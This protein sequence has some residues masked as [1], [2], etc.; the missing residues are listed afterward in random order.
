MARQPLIA[1]ANPTRP[2]QLN[3]GQ[4][5]AAQAGAFADL[6]QATA[7]VTNVFDQYAQVARDKALDETMR[8]AENEFATIARENPLAPDA[9]QKVADEKIGTLIAKSDG[10]IARD[11]ERGLINR[12]DAYLRSI[13]D[14]KFDFDVKTQRDNFLTGIDNNQN[15]LRSLVAEKGL[16]AA[17]LPEWQQSV[18]EALSRVDA[19]AA[20]PL[21]GVGGEEA[22]KLRDGIL[23]EA[24]TSLIVG[25]IGDEVDD[26][27][28]K[29]GASGA[30]KRLASL[31]DEHGSTLFA[32]E[33]LKFETHGER[34]IQSREAE[35]ERAIR[36]SEAARAKT[37]AE[38]YER[39][40]VDLSDGRLTRADADLLWQDGEIDTGHYASLV[41]HLNTRGKKSEAEA[42]SLLRIDA[43]VAEGSS[44]NPYSKTD[45]DDIDLYWSAIGGA[46]AMT[47]DPATARAML[48]A[49][50]T[51][52]GVIPPMAVDMLQGQM[53]HGDDAQRGEAI[54]TL[55]LLYER[56]PAAVEQ[57]LPSD[58]LGDVIAYSEMVNAGTPQAT[59]QARV[60]T[61]REARFSEPKKALLDAAK[62]SSKKIQSREVA[63]PVNGFF[64]APFA[65]GETATLKATSEYRR[66]YESAFVGSN[67]NEKAARK[68][69]I[70][71]LKRVYGV[72]NVTGSARTMPY[73]PERYYHVS[74]VDDK[75]MQAALK[76]EVEDWFG[77]RGSK[78]NLERVALIP[79]STTAAEAQQPGGRPGYR[80]VVEM[81]DGDQ[82][83]QFEEIPGRYYFPDEPIRANVEAKSAE[84]TA[85]KR[86]FAAGVREAL[87]ENKT[88]RRPRG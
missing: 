48:A 58:Q 81:K 65:G 85:K 1:P 7:Q 36:E 24:Q 4:G 14:K 15:T 60:D 37:Q 44:L 72:S 67:G 76:A 69:A 54:D 84:K 23:R 18:D 25:T 79:D 88:P 62:E 31:L 11:L 47:S 71:D 39:A 56:A 83:G 86:E 2:A 74:G 77:A 52:T 20:N 80:V 35:R 26:A 64:N 73:P 19:L 12:R 53:L 6:A 30:R 41:E 45:R 34:V 87:E 21:Y 32:D 68:T 40:R 9:F 55:K 8:A 33:R 10:S 29:G 50:A 43:A 63:N 3:L 78:V 49:T 57:A 82:A 70:A 75:W 38:I 13:A 28:S 59:A 51:K 27:Y 66:A 22:T 17:S 61:V 46:E 42:L 16:A 5:A